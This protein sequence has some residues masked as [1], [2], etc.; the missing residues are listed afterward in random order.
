M[1]LDVDF[2]EFEQLRDRMIQLEK[3]NDA[4]MQKCVNELTARL[5]RRVK[6]RTP[7][8]NKE[9]TLRII[10]H[11]EQTR[12]K[13]L[14]EGYRLDTGNKSDHDF[15]RSRAYVDESGKIITLEQ[16]TIISADVTPDEEHPDPKP[17]TVNGDAG[18]SF[19][20][21][22]MPYLVWKD[23]QYGYM[24]YGPASEVDLLRMAESLL[25]PDSQCV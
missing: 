17:I 23:G 11:G 6:Q 24:L 18:Y 9:R 7:V 22:G 16:H 13:W 8:W 4:F 20:G 25:I 2:G 12:H 21:D 5:L 19:I 15:F 3:N 14:P 1:S 10:Q